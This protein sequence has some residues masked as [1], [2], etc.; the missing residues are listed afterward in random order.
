MREYAHWSV[1]ERWYES[2]DTE[3][4]PA[5]IR[6]KKRREDCQLLT[7]KRF[8]DTRPWAREPAWHDLDQRDQNVL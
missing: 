8:G 5:T 2:I 7:E 4:L 1:M 6:M 3:E